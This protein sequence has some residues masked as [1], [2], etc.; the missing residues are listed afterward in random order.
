M[1]EP[2]KAELALVSDVADVKPLPGI[3]NLVFTDQASRTM[4]TAKGWRKYAQSTLTQQQITATDGFL[5]CRL[6]QD[7]GVTL[8]ELD[9][10]AT[11]VKSQSCPLAAENEVAKFLATKLYIEHVKP[12]GRITNDLFI[13]KNRRT[14]KSVRQIAIDGDITVSTSLKDP[15]ANPTS[16]ASLGVVLALTMDVRVTPVTSVQRLVYLIACGIHNMIIDSMIRNT[17]YVMTQVSAEATTDTPDSTA[18]PTSNLRSAIKR[19]A[20][21]LKS[22]PGSFGEE[23]GKFAAC[24]VR[25]YVVLRTVSEADLVKPFDEDSSLESILT[26]RCTQQG[27]KSTQVNQVAMLANML[28]DLQV[29][30]H[31]PNE[32]SLAEYMVKNPLRPVFVPPIQDVFGNLVPAKYLFWDDAT[33]GA[34][35]GDCVLTLPAQSCF[36]D[37]AANPSYC[38]LNKVTMFGARAGRTQQASID[39]AQ[40]L[41]SPNLALQH[42]QKNGNEN[43]QILRGDE[44][45]DLLM[46]AAMDDFEAAM[47][48]SE[49]GK[50]PRL[51]A[52]PNEQE[53]GGGR[54]DSD[55]DRDKSQN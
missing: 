20:V 29:T 22:R 30:P 33:K 7:I 53:E 3:P 42:L 12:K 17:S 25:T 28:G 21:E 39:F 13:C 45:D 55:E 34:Y 6:A 15:V 40:V 52:V 51:E 43:L 47:T 35:Q 31:V 38:T 54:V 44:A 9:E 49:R 4:I 41:F 48:E 16:Q 37:N 19:L 10:L 14:S 23:T 50:R 26:A 5:L 11:F 27:V 8:A 32:P 36:T 2:K 46:M 24:A 1:A 18:L